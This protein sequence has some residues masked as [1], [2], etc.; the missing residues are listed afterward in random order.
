MEI[1]SS[2]S[3][4]FLISIVVEEFSDVIGRERIYSGDL[5][6]L[7]ASS[8]TRTPTISDSGISNIG[9]SKIRS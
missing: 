1:L 2:L 3:S 9:S 8:S 5:F 7:T 6:V 4:V